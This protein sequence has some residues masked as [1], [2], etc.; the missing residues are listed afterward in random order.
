MARDVLRSPASS[1]Y[2]VDKWAI[3]APVPTGSFMT[4][5]DGSIVN[6]S[7][8]AIARSFGVPRAEMV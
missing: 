6:I 4:T 3:L 7:L 8:P 2:R 1:G 5:V